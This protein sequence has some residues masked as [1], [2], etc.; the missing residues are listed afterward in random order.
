VKKK[1]RSTLL[2]RQQERNIVK[3]LCPNHVK[4]EELSQRDNEEKK[5]PTYKKK[6]NWV[7]HVLRKNVFLKT[8]LWKR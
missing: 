1:I 6:A 5:H 4:N 7:G 3:L 8:L 2:Q